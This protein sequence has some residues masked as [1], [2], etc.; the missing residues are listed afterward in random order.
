MRSH[1][2][3]MSW[4]KDI[5]SCP[6]VPDEFAWCCLFASLIP[7]SPL[8]AFLPPP[9]LQAACPSLPFAFC[10]PAL[11]VCTGD[12]LGQIITASSVQWLE[13]L[14]TSLA[15]LTG[16]SRHHA[17]LT[18]VAGSLPFASQDYWLRCKLLD[19]RV[20]GG[21][22]GSLWGNLSC[23]FIKIQKGTCPWLWL[24]L[25]TRGCLSPGQRKEKQ[26]QEE[27]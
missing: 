15:E 9:A 11:F 1:R 2:N 27:Q 17:G 4:L 19:V 23:S 25:K 3:G 5:W 20:E 26:E 21:S 12:F 8:P 7:S 16:R 22:P 10:P 13:A 18:R 6:G 24:A 14:G